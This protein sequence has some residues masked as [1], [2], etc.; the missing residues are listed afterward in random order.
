LVQ[1]F[2][3]KRFKCESL[4]RTTDGRTD[5]DGRQVMAKAKNVDLFF[6]VS[7][8]YPVRTEIFYR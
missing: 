3:R 7:K 2:Q 1:R 6:F 4:R 5:Y 8:C